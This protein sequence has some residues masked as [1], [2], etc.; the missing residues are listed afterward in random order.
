MFVIFDHSFLAPDKRVQSLPNEIPPN[1]PKRSQKK[2]ASSLGH[3]DYLPLEGTPSDGNVSLSSTNGL[4]TQIGN[5]DLRDSGISMTEP[6][7]NNFNVC[8]EDFEL[9]G[10][11][12][13]QQ[14]EL[15]INSSPPEEDEPQL[16]NPPPIPPK[17]NLSFSMDLNSSLERP[18]RRTNSDVTS[19]ENYSQPKFQKDTNTSKVDDSE[20]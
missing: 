1:I 12:G 9:R 2:S 17:S 7:L 6:Q 8:Y 19:P 13:G 14:T 11:G 15:N 10:G 3:I 16:E 20:A 5:H 4:T 18:K